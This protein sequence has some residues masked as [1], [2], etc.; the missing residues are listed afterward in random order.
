MIV[1]YLRLYIK[2]VAEIQHFN[3]IDFLACNLIILPVS[4]AM[5]LGQYTCRAHGYLQRG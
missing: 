4:A 3:H 1:Y 2:K 5:E